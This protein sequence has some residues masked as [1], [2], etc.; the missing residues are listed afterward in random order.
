MATKT[1]PDKA[2]LPDASD[3]P[4]YWFVE[5]ERAISEGNFVAAATAQR[6]L[7]RLGV[8]VR[9]RQR[10]QSEVANAN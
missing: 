7:E 4:S 5:L 9:W 3:W 2:A 1:K 8:T 6:E 10:G